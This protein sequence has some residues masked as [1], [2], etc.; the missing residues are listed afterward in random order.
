MTGCSVEG[1]VYSV[2]CTVYI[3]QC[4]VCVVQCKAYSQHIW[5]YVFADLSLLE[6]YELDLLLEQA[7]WAEPPYAMLDKRWQVAKISVENYLA[8][9]Y[10]LYC[11]YF[12]VLYFFKDVN[13][14]Y[15]KNYFYISVFIYLSITFNE[16]ETN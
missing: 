14:C 11:L 2:H 4:T 8:A 9:Y 1:T 5:G 3:L 10:F 13:L 15:V 16:K 6:S 7:T 12:L